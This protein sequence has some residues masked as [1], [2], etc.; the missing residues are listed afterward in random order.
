MNDR[1]EQAWHELRGGEQVP[2][3]A[4]LVKRRTP[5][6]TVRCPR[7]QELVAGV[8]GT[9]AGPLL[10]TGRRASSA[11]GVVA[12]TG[13]FRFDTPG[14]GFGQGVFAGARTWT[15]RFT[16]ASESLAEAFPL[17]CHRCRSNTATT[18]GVLAGEVVA[19]ISSGAPR[20]L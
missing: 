8:W 3:L 11:E 10:V 13:V 14:Q 15:P 2:S 1:A 19:A 6:V 16:L 4:S 20:R 12:G 7:D 18:P 9:S 5:L 17:H